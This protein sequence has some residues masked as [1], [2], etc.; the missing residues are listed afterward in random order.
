[1]SG[2]NLF[3]KLSK[4]DFSGSEADLY[5][6]ELQTMFSHFAASG[7]ISEFYSKLETAEK[8]GQKLS[9]ADDEADEYSVESL[10]FS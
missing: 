7:E 8:N 10:T 2:E 4:R 5:A 3:L 6:Q 9:L 1:M